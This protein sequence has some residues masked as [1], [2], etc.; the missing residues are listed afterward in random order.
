MDSA[1][2]AFNLRHQFDGVNPDGSSVMEDFDEESVSD[3]YGSYGDFRLVGHGEVTSDDCGVFRSFMICDRVDLHDHVGLDGVNYKGKVFVRKIHRSCDKSS[4][5]VCYKYG[6][7]SREAHKIEVRLAEG[8]KHFGLVEHIVA[9]VPLKD[10][11]LSYEVLRSKIVKILSV[12]GV[13]GGNLIFHGFRFNSRKY[14]YWSPHWHCLGF[15]LGGYGCRGCKKV[16][17]KGCG[18]FEDKTRRCFESDGYIVKVLDKRKTVGGTAWYQLEHST[19]KVSV[20][21]FHVA[22]W[23]GVCSYRKLK[24]TVEKRKVLCPICGSDLFWADYY[25]VKRF[26]LD[27]DSPDYRRDSVEDLMEGGRVVWVVRQRGER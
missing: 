3:G 9:S 1:E 17:F 23:F 10:Y 13:I 8:A 18:E 11:S 4:C 22:T 6:W 25:G 21:H 16:C 5:P 24:V 2:F 26:V 27:R 7:A 15:I 14:P 19:V 20:E 12:R